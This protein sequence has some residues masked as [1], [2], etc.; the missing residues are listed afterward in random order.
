[1]VKTMIYNNRYRDLNLGTVS[2]ALLG[3]CKLEELDR[4]Q[5]QKL[6]TEKQV[7]Y[8]A[9]DANLVMKLSKHNNYEMLDLMNAVSIITKVS[10]DKVCH[11]GISSWWKKI[12]VDKINSG[13]C[14]SPLSTVKKQ[15][16]KGG[17]VIAPL[18]GDYRNQVVYV[19]DVKSLYPTMMI[20]NNISFEIISCDCCKDNLEG[21]LPRDYGFDK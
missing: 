14:R 2:K 19:L 3:E 16:Y 8:V 9:Q 15:T 17:Q 11:T 6:R 21:S 20:I 4:L 12:I 1:M 5:I 18:M 7:E 13:E 10:F